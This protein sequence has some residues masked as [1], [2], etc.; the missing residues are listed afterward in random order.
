MNTIPDGA[1]AVR[2]F[3]DRYF[4]TRDGDIFNSNG[5]RMSPVRD[6]ARFL[7]VYLTFDTRQ[8]KGVYV[9]RVVAEHFLRRRP[10]FNL[11]EFID[12]NKANCHVDNLAWTSPSEKHGHYNIFTKRKE[13]R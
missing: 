6:T 10:G 8:T 3:G 9:H 12:G 4:V 7:R 2:G 11:V 13:K 5:H 1:K